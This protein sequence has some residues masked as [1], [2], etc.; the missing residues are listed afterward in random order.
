[1]IN[2]AA[3]RASTTELLDFAD[4]LDDAPLAVDDGHFYD[5]VLEDV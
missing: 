3:P 2:A 5:D 4:D 1:M